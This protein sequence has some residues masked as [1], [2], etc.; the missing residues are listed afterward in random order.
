MKIRFLIVIVSI[1]LSSL[2]WAQSVGVGTNT[3]H[4]SA[5]L[6]IEST[7]QGVLVPRMT[8]HQRSLIALPA[9]GLLV[10]QTDAN[11]GFYFYN[12]ITWQSLTA[13][14]SITPPA[15]GKIVYIKNSENSTAGVRDSIYV[16][17][18]DGTNRIYIPVVIPNY[19]NAAFS[20]VR[21]SPDG[22]KVF[23]IAEY[24]PTSNQYTGSIYSC[25]LDG[26][27]LTKLID[28]GINLWRFE[29]GGVY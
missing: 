27:N 28:S 19:P 22:T 18:H 16:A 7:T 23:F 15:L 24:F 2:S 17:N 1:G 3:P 11:Q 9:I 25:N 10:Y 6:D 26:S 12:G 29:M 20:G 8:A 13:G 4:S 5:K 21:L 14:G